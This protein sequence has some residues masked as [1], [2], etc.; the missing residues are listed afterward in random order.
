MFTGLIEELGTIKSIDPQGDG[1]VFTIKASTVLDDVNVDDS[2]AV[3]GCCLTVTSF[4]D[5]SFTVTAIA[6]TLKKTSLGTFTHNTPVNLERAVRLQDRLG[7]HM[8]LGHVDCTGTITKI[9]TNDQ[10][11]EMWVDFPAEYGKWLIPVGSVTL[12]GISLTVAELEE[13]RLK[14]ALIPHTLQATSL[15]TAKE[16]DLVNIEFDMMAK[17]IEKLVTKPST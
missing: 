7:G 10:G 16:G 12:N 9:T 14:V 17:Y 2:I 4:N 15:G 8:V 6:E 3:N 1:S 11:W 5:D 13:G